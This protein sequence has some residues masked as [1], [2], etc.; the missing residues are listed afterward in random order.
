MTPLNQIHG[1]FCFEPIT[2][3][4]NDVNLITVGTNKNSV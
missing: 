3:L 2:L 4:I 1:L